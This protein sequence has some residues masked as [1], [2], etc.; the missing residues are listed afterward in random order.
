VPR[1]V[2]ALTLLHGL[3]LVHWSMLVPT[4]HA[5]DEPA[6][7]DQV[8][9]ARTGSGWPA[10]DERFISSRILDSFDHSFFDA[11]GPPKDGRSA[12][13]RGRRPAFEDLG[14]DVP[15]LSANQQSQHPPLYYA[16]VAAAVSATVVMAPL[17]G[18]WA[19]DQTVWLMRFYGG[20][21]LLTPLPALAWLAARRLGAPPPAA[22][23]AAVIPL[24]VPQLT[25]IGSTVN[26]DNLL[27]LLVTV[28]TVLLAGVLAG[29][30]TVRTGLRIGVTTAGALLTKGFALALP[31]VV[32]AAYAVGWA[33]TRALAGLRA[34]GVALGVALAAG[35]WWWLRN[36]VVHGTLQPEDP[37]Y[38]REAAEAAPA[39]AEWWGWFT[40][41]MVR[42]FWGWFGW[43]EVAL[44]AW[45]PWTATVLLVA[46]VVLAF[47]LRG[48][49]P[50][51]RPAQAVLLLPLL[52]I[53]AV[54]AVGGW[55]K[56]AHSGVPDGLQ[57]RYLFPGLVAFSLVASV[58]YARALGRHARWLAPAVLV[59]AG[60][61]QL[62]GTWIS[63]LRFWGVGHGELTS[64]RALLAWAPW[65]PAVL[66]LTW[67]GAAAA[68]TWAL[69]ELVRRPA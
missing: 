14:P 20:I 11:H 67:G 56:F 16:A 50:P 58:G 54:V 57:G 32:A 33:R 65:P 8:F 12:A 46:G 68:G 66:L 2:W 10:P 34:A 6:H 52:G 19:Y 18:G 49:E 60:L 43:F 27:T 61:L 21:V 1:A 41:F 4:Y 35:G 36:L 44:P 37:R 63:L 69:V 23:T 24:A 59:L 5:P 22:T 28:L 13:P 42:R 15:T 47:A 64:L 29:D 3:L 45:I 9:V 30:Q 38:A 17:Q 51:S 53:L 26:N 55:A 48:A 25:H 7:V 62:E 39:F 31:A 40:M